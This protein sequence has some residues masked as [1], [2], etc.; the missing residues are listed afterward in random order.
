MLVLPQ[1]AAL[2]ERFAPAF[3]DPTYRRFLVLCVGAIVTMGRRSVSRI[4]WSVGCLSEGHPSSYHRF[5]SKAVWSAWPLSRVLAAAVLELAG[6]VV[7]ID[8][9][10]TVDQHRGKKV[11]GKGCHRD[12]V[13]SSWGHTVFKWGHKWVVLA[14]NIKLPGCSRYWALPIMAALYTP[15]PQPAA[16][17]KRKKRKGKGKSRGGQGGKRRKAK[18]RPKTPARTARHKTPAVLARQMLAV[19]LHWFPNR[20][21]I[22]LG[23]WG[24]ASHDLALFC[25]RHA[26]QVTLIGRMRS[27]T[28]LYSLPSAPVPGR[29]GRPRRKGT[30]LPTPA[31]CAAR[32]TARGTAEVRWY[33]NSVRT[34]ELLCGCGGW[35]RGRGQGCAALV[36]IRWVITRDPTSGRE[37]YFY[38]TDTSLNAVQIVEYFAH[39]WNIEVTFEEVR[40]HLGFETTRQWCRNSVQRTGAMVLGLFSV[41]SLIYAELARQ[42][43]VKVHATPCYAKTEPTFADALAAVRTLFWQ[44]I[45][46]QHVPGGQLVAKLPQGIRDLLLD[47]L[48]AAA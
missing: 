48:A 40:A 7:E 20:K 42:K 12:A 13:R 33:G 21:F 22:L 29:R 3:T 17:P 37:D 10:D 9:D 27:D 18:A 34:L 30:K 23:D 45:I 14:V 36:P 32:A 19:L 8:A 24:F 31:Q 16:R 41:V 26:D 2:L 15:P 39:R 46:L 35:Y 43:K 11:Y 28:N 6:K 25:H 1:E 4:L 38:S 5:F 44:E 47:R